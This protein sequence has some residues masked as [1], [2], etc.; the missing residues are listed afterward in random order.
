MALPRSSGEW[1]RVQCPNHSPPVLLPPEKILLDL[2]GEPRQ[3]GQ[4][5]QQES[6]LWPQLP[7]SAFEIQLLLV[8]VRLWAPLLCCPVPLFLYLETMTGATLR[9]RCYT[10]AV[11][12]GPGTR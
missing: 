6:W 4:R 8:A 7:Q 12:I 2:S 3:E 9:T 10:Q 5:G 11:G 1:P